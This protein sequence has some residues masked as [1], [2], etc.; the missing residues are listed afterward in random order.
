MIAGLILAAG[1]SRRMARD[2]ALLTYRGQTFLE[3]IVQ[4][5]RAGGIEK[6]AVVLGHHADEI[7]RAVNLSGVQV[8][9]NPA[10]QRGQTSSLQAGL[11]A[12]QALSPEGVM[13]CLVDHPAVPAEVLRNLL[14][15]FEQSRSAVIIP[16]FQ[17]QRGHPILIGRALFPE[18]LALNPDE[19]ANAVIRKYLHAT[20]LVE[21]ENQGILLDVDDPETYHRL[22]PDRSTQ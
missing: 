12:L 3:T 11:G 10:Y 13:L 21:V 6:I 15:Q 14:A 22:E 5:L 8:V 17:G 16:T 18:L 7:Q 4:T 19:G 9:V 2:K 1:E 20:Q